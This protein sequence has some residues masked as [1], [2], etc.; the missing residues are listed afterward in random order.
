MDISDN[1]V[2]LIVAGAVVTAAG[3]GYVTYKKG[4]KDGVR[5][6]A[7]IQLGLYDDK[8]RKNKSPKAK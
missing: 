1:A 7:A 6:G 8:L 2:K 3:L 4:R 5:L